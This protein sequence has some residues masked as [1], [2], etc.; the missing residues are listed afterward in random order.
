MEF[1]ETPIPK[2][3]IRNDKFMNDTTF[4]DYQT[5]TELLDIS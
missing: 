4:K 5:E 1:S 2:K 3:Y